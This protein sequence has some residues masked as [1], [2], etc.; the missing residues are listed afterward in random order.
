MYNLEPQALHIWSETGK[1]EITIVLGLPLMPWTQ[2]L[3]DCD[4]R[5]ELPVNINK[6]SGNDW[7][8]AP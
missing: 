6:S 4:E 7:R 5:T 2:L 1:L 3:G 8:L